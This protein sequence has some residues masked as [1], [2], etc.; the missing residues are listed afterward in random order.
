MPTISSFGIGMA[1]MPLRISDRTPGAILQ[2]QP[3]P[4]DRL[5]RRGC[6]GRVLAGLG[7][8]E[9]IK[10]FPIVASSHVFQSPATRTGRDTMVRGV[11]FGVV[12]SC[13]IIRKYQRLSVMGV[14]QRTH[15]TRR[16]RLSQ[17]SNA[18]P[19][20]VANRARFKRHY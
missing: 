7:V 17:P 5:V 20:G 15:D 3:P 8:S 12:G 14:F 19:T 11:Y 2:P 6:L 10:F 13:C 9:V 18:A 16:R 1:V 4:W